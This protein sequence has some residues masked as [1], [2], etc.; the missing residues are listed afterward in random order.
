MSSVCELDF[1]SPLP[2]EVATYVIYYIPVESMY[3]AVDV[4]V[5]IVELTAKKYG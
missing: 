4:I 2:P 5:K 3:K 1:D